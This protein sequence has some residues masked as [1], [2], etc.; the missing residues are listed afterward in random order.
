MWF[1][2]LAF[3]F[4][5][6]I[7]Y[8]FKEG[9][10]R[11]ED[12]CKSEKN[13]KPTYSDTRGNNYLTHNG[14]KVIYTTDRNG[15]WVLKDAKTLE[16][17]M[18]FSNHPKHR[19]RKEEDVYDCSGQFKLIKHRKGDFFPYVITCF[20]NYIFEPHYCYGAPHE[21]YTNIEDKKIYANYWQYFGSPNK[22]PRQIVMRTHGNYKIAILYCISE[23]KVICYA[24]EGVSNYVED[25]KL[26][27]KRGYSMTINDGKLEEEVKSNKVFDCSWMT[28]QALQMYEDID[29]KVIKLFET[30]LNKLLEIHKEKKYLYEKS[31]SVKLLESNGFPTH[32][33]IKE[34]DY[35]HDGMAVI[36]LDNYYNW[37]Y[38]YDDTILKEIK[39]EYKEK[40]LKL[41]DI[42]YDYK[43]TC[44]EDRLKQG[45]LIKCNEEP[46][47]DRF[48]NYYS[49]LKTEIENINV[50]EIASK[51][52]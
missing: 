7:I 28:F 27:E 24:P 26:A 3:A 1:I 33:D 37:T 43:Y 8:N 14:K 39:K 40:F 6:L 11:F 44:F 19:Q 49:K 20:D 52:K 16:T 13:H 45:K 36:D 25:I 41:F 23:P 4:I 18:N 48:N 35:I 5:G 22:K 38:A 42:K 12:R 17:V 47:L 10:Y 31:E 9:Y 30:F 2:F 29:I 51:L 50:K 46:W 21:F 15:D 32:R 34:C